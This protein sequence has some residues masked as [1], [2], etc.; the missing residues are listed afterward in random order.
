M[1]AIINREVRSNLLPLYLKNHSVGKVHSKFNNGLNIQFG[2][3]LIYISSTDSSLSAFG[4]NIGKGKLREILDSA[5]TDDIVV[6]KN[7]MLILYCT[8]QIIT[9]NYK[10]AEQV[11]LTLPQI[12]CSVS[13]IPH[14]KL[15]NYLK[16]IDFKESIGI[17]LD[18]ITLKYLDLMMD[19]GKEDLD[20]DSG[21]I[22]FFSGRGKG[23]T[24]S[25]DDIIIGFTLALRMFGDFHKWI[26][27]LKLELLENRTTFI[28]RMYLKALLEGYVSEDLVQLAGLVDS[29]DIDFIERTIR[30]VQAFGHTSGNDTLFGFYLGLKFLI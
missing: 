18:E 25:G 4:L 30:K 5:E 10:N 26:E 27:A 2:D 13:E 7:E 16:E 3:F 19:T 17:D 29:E 8:N 24:P 15:Y 6:N 28:S 20:I 12:K 22:R 11:N 14:T 1:K 21:I 9:I 23:L